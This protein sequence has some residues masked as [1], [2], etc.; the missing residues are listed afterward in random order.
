MCKFLIMQFGTQYGLS[1][2]QPTCKF[3]LRF[4]AL[5][6]NNNTIIFYSTVY[7]YC[8]LWLDAE[9]RETIVVCTERPGS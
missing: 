4:L 1:R 8:I 6:Y 5:C 3:P 7:C 2:T 9:T